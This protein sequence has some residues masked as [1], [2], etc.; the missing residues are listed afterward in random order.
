MTSKYVWIKKE[1]PT[2]SST[3]KNRMKFHKWK[4]RISCKSIQNDYTISVVKIKLLS[5]FGIKDVI[6]SASVALLNKL[7]KISE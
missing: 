2:I 5:S 4:S 7:K 3:K 1:V 6:V